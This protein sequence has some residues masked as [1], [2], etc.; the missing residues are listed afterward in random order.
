VNCAGKECGSIGRGGLTDTLDQRR[1]HDRLATPARI[2][3]AAARI[4]QLVPEFAGPSAGRA[5]ILP[6]CGGLGELRW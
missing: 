1:G 4:A 6:A 3:H 5:E 2:D